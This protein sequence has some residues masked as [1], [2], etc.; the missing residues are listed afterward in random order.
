MFGHFYSLERQKHRCLGLSDMYEEQ[1]HG[2]KDLSDVFDG[3]NMNVFRRRG[4]L[5][6]L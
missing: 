1:K 2:V 4:V 3:R 6:E 5:D